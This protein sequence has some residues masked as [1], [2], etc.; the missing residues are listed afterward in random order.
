MAHPPPRKSW[1]DCCR[2][3][4]MT[5][6][7]AK[8]TNYCLTMTKALM[9]PMV[10]TRSMARIDWMPKTHWL[11][12]NCMTR[13]CSSTTTRNCLLGSPKAYLTKN[14]RNYWD[15]FRVCCSM[16]NCLRDRFQMKSCYSS[17]NHHSMRNCYCWKAYYRSSTNCLFL[18]LPSLNCCWRGHYHSMRNCYSQVIHRWTRNCWRGGVP[19]LDDELPLD[20]GPPLEDEPLLDSDP[21]PPPLDELLDEELL[22]GGTYVP[23]ELLDDS[24]VSGGG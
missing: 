22:T 16:R 18:N 10:Q 8:T 7:W 23:D 20:G 12:R 4:W 5:R 24:L 13:S 19:P 1:R 17:V 3:K 2:K 14:S 15:H 21:D 6:K 11:A 9:V